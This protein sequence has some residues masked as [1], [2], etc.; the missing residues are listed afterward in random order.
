MQLLVYCITQFNYIFFKMTN[1]I[2]AC[3]QTIKNNLITLR[4]IING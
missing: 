3:V 1:K 4:L 2:N